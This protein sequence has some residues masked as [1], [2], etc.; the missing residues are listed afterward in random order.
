M[1]HPLGSIPASARPD[2]FRGV[3][4]YITQKWCS[5]QWENAVEIRFRAKMER[6]Q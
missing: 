1:Q 3:K 5:L 2:S 4:T 6:F